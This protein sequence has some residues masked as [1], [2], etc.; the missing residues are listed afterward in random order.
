M[1]SAVTPQWALTARAEASRA[2]FAST[3]NF[4]VP[5]EPEVA[6]TT[7]EQSPQSPSR[8]SRNPAESTGRFGFSRMSIAADSQ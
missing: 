6:M 8:N 1:S 2:D 4:T 7:A 5:L 3:T